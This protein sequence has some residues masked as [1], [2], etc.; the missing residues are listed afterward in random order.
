M[1]PK[2]KRL[3]EIEY[4]EINSNPTTELLKEVVLASA[5]ETIELVTY[6]NDV[7]P[8]A[9]VNY[10]PLANPRSEYLEE[11]PSSKEKKDFKNRELPKT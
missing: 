5:Q 2:R 11:V 4:S 10:R 3:L 7:T 1:D 8:E 6:S 9:N